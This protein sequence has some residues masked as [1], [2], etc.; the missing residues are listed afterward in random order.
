MKLS[1]DLKLNRAERP[2]E[3]TMDRFIRSAIQLEARAN[4][5][6]DENGWWCN[7]CN[8]HVDGSE[9]TYTEHHDGCGGR[10]S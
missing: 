10:C 7:K 5:D 9:V 2:D 4:G 3:W 8:S 1:E 6:E